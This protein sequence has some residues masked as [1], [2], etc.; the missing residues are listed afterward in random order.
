MSCDVCGW[1]W[2]AGQSHWAIPSSQTM[3]AAQKQIGGAC[4]Q[5]LQA[6]QE[7]GVFEESPRQVKK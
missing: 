2:P 5:L 7:R 4:S 3:S 1:G 6:R